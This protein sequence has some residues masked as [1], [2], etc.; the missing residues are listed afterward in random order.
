M[1]PLL[2][3]Y[4]SYFAAGSTDIRRAFVNSL[5]FVAGFTV[6]FITLGAF[7]GTLGRLLIIHNVIINIITGAIVILF[8]LNYLGIINISFLNRSANRIIKAKDLKFT[9]SVI[10]GLAFSI[11]WTPCVGA[12]LGS[13]L[14]KASMYGGVLNGVIMLLLYSVGLGIPFIISAVL[15]DRLK[16]AVDFI[17]NNYKIINA[18]S[19]SMLVIIGI[20]MATGL[21]GRFLTALSV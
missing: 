11:G 13:A 20:M 14:M 21:M 10:F 5:G 19:G 18:I 9:S 8:G 16:G 1:L 3:V 17:K 6:V 4:V 15:I 7:A 2:P 12:F